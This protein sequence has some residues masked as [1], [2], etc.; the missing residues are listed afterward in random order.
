MSSTTEKEIEDNVEI[1][2]INTTTLNFCVLILFPC[3]ETVCPIFLI[4]LSL[5]TSSQDTRIGVMGVVAD[6][7]HHTN[8][9]H[10]NA[11]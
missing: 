4:S 3:S 11:F 10:N 6:F 5:F 2:K 7:S 1:S 8:L 9:Y